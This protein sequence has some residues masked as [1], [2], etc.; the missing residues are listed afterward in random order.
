MSSAVSFTPSTDFLYPNN[1][2]LSFMA[3]NNSLT[4]MVVPTD[5]HDQA[6]GQIYYYTR[7]SASDAWSNKIQIQGIPVTGI[8]WTHASMSA[9]GDRLVVL[10]LFTTKPGCLF[11]V[12]RSKF[13]L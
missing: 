1:G 11:F 12:F 3:I 2:F 4:R 5:G 13:T 9:N 8:R 10:S 6:L 7:A